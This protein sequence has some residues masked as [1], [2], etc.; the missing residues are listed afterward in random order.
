MKKNFTLFAAMLFAVV[1]N[2]A[3]DAGEER[4]DVH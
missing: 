4:F 2:A 3:I 1:T